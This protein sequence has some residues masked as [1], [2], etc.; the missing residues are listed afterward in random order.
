[1]TRLVPK[2]H[3]EADFDIGVFACPDPAPRGQARILKQLQDARK[4]DQPRS[5]FFSCAICYS[6]TREPL[7]MRAAV[8]RGR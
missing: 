8:L 7:P 2:F 1:M 5:L 4:P 3:R 6:M